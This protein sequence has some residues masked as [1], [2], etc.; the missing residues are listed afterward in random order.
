MNYQGSFGN[1]GALTLMTLKVLSVE[2]GKSPRTSE[3]T[4][5]QKNAVLGKLYFL[6]GVGVEG[7]GVEGEQGSLFCSSSPTY[8]TANVFVYGQKNILKILIITSI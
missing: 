7:V 8:V 5:C 2:N 1:T 4:R 3:C 6:A